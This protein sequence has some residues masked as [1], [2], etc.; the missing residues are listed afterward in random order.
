VARKPTEKS[1]LPAEQVNYWRTHAAVLC[2]WRSAQVYTPDWQ[3]LCYLQQATNMCHITPSSPACSQSCIKP[4]LLILYCSSIL[5]SLAYCTI[6][7]LN[8]LSFS[9]SS[10]FSPPRLT[11]VL[12]KMLTIMHFLPYFLCTCNQVMDCTA[13]MVSPTVATTLLQTSALHCL[14]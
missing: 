14:T 11:S 6:L 10:I 13:F 4:W 12:H 7:N 2:L 1:S 5:I 3:A 9:S 8:V